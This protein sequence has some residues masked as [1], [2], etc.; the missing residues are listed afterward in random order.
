MLGYLR[1]MVLCTLAGLVI[2]TVFMTP[3]GV[4]AGA[5][6]GLFLGIL[7]TWGEWKAGRVVEVVSYVTPERRH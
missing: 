3:G 1:I 7:I 4:A 6:K 2:A 5:V